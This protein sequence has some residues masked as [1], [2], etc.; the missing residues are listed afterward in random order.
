RGWQAKMGD[1]LSVLEFS[2]PL[3]S[4][5]QNPLFFQQ[6]FLSLARRLDPEQGY[7]GL[8]FNL[9]PTRRDDNEPTE[10]FMAQRMPGLDVGLSLIHISE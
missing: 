2:V 6:L 10:A 1:G 4:Q 7:A 3:L 5:E 9:S 8:A